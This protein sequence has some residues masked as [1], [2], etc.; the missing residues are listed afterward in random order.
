MQ[1][2]R[3]IVIVG[4][5][6]SGVLVAAHVARHPSPTP[7][8]VSLVD[9]RAAVGSGTAFGTRRPCH[10][11]NVPAARMSAFADEPEHF[12]HWAR[13]VDPSIGPDTFAMRS[14]YGDYLRDVLHDAR[15]ADTPT[16]LELVTGEVAAIDPNDEQARVR[17]ADGGKLAADAVVL[18]LGNA[19]PAE[20]RVNGAPLSRSTRYV[21]DPW[22]PGALDGIGEHDPVLLVGTGLTAVDVVLALVSRGH[23]ADLRCVSRHGLVPMA[24]APYAPAPELRF[25]A[26]RSAPSAT[27]HLHALRAEVRRAAALGIDWRAVVDGLRPHTQQLWAGLPIAERR[28]FLRH[29]ARYWEV[30]RHRMAPPVARTIG[31][32]VAE[33]RVTVERGRLVEYDETA[34]RVVVRVRDRGEAREVP[35]AYVV[36]CTGPRPDIV[37]AGDPV[38]D[39][40]LDRG[41]VRAGPLGLGLDCDAAG[42]LIDASGRVSERMWTLGS[43]RRGA[44]W[45]T[46]AVGEIRAQAAA[47]A[48]SLLG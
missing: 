19:S 6:V 48:D 40:L 30:H 17:F 16:E 4:G 7:R 31:K 35:A 43:L 22:R 5:G 20:P 37:N 47:L 29:A 15:F 21:R 1:T 9:R 8:H 32:L 26:V 23:R 42:A 12:L 14:L 10:L 2:E 33:G 24:H 46:T 13:I 18:A 11:L 28:R 36:N 41:A 45:E 34:D 25:D 3:R 44:L 27:A 38:V 39:A